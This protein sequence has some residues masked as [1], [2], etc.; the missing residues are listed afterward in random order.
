MAYI[1]KWFHFY[2]TKEAFDEHMNANVI[3][4]TSICF[5]D[6]TGQIAAQG[7]LFG[8]NKID[9]SNLKNQVQKHEEDLRNIL[10][11]EGPSVGDGNINN[12]ADIINFL[13]TFG[14]DDTLK[15]CLDNIKKQIR[16]L[17]NTKGKPNGI[18]PL[19]SDAKISSVYLPSYVDDV[20]EY[21]SVSKFPAV[22]ET[23]K[24]YV[25][26]DTDLTYRWSGTTYVEISK[27]IALGET[28]TTAYPGDKGKKNA[29]DIAAQKVILDKL[30]EDFIPTIEIPANLLPSV[31]DTGESEAIDI[32]SYLSDYLVRNN[33]SYATV[34]HSLYLVIDGRVLFL[35]KDKNYAIHASYEGLLFKD[36]GTPNHYGILYPSIS[37]SFPLKAFL[38]VE[39]ADLDI[40]KLDSNFT[41]VDITDEIDIEEMLNADTPYSIDLTNN[42]LVNKYFAGG[43]CSD[44]VC[45][46]WKNTLFYF[47]NS[48]TSTTLYCNYYNSR[49]VSLMLSA[50]YTDRYGQTITLSFSNKYADIYKGGLMSPIDKKKL[51]GIDTNT[52]LSTEDKNKLDNI[53]II[54]I[55]VSNTVNDPT[56]LQ[57]EEAI[58][59]DDT[60]TKIYNAYHENTMVYKSL[61]ILGHDASELYQIVSIDEDNVISGKFYL[62]FIG[63]GSSGVISFGKLEIGTIEQG[64]Y[65]TMPK[66]TS[67]SG[68]A[69]SGDD[70][71]M[72]KEDKKKLDKINNTTVYLPI[73]GQ[74]LE[75]FL[76]NGLINSESA[77][78]TSA[79]VLNA[80]SFDSD[81]NNFTFGFNC[82]GSGEQEIIRAKID[83]IEKATTQGHEYNKLYI[84]MNYRNNIYFGTVNVTPSQVSLNITGQFQII[85]PITQ[86]ELDDILN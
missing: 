62:G 34:N 60:Y 61:R 78:P 29:D 63:I 50:A 64:S 52:L 58:I 22:G 17:E 20:L 44:K 76:E 37:T 27:S 65:I 19:G 83:N 9:Y 4:P 49:I 8:V 31:P 16:D 79:N 55:D 18:A 59:D 70:G 1:D 6:E 24:I 39:S 26:L 86:T 66:I 10:G 21:T 75:E 45:F 41:I 54:T 82:L 67:Y 15:N 48:S 23:G 43:V 35:E 3:S 71:L 25:A 46:K 7:S 38:N 28:S 51:D 13:S 42:E 33:T 30:D 81:L 36:T 40:D 32:T 85:R 72:S 56:Y 47:N 57:N 14:E 2:G 69:T 68:L 73:L 11:I 77:D 80:L 53:E 84:S 5:I 74:S 12:L